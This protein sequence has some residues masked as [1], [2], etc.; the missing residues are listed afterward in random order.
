MRASYSFIIIIAI[1]I[2]LQACKTDISVNTNKK[3]DVVAKNLQIAWGLAYL[4]NGDF[5]F[6]ERM[7]GKIYLIKKG[8]TEP[9]VL[10]Q[11]SI[12]PDGEGGLLG[13]A[14]D[15]E[16]NQNHYIF[17]YE[18]TSANRVVRLRYDN[19]TLAEDAV[20]VDGIPSATYHNGGGLKFGP[21]GYL[22]IGTGDARVPENAQDKNSV[23]GKILRVDRNGNAA[24]G[25]PFNNKVWTYGHRNVQGFAW[26]NNG[27]ML[28][29]EHGPSGENGWYAH[30]EINLIQP[31]KNYGWPLVIGAPHVDTLMDPVYQSGD[32]TWAPSGITFITG[33]QWDAWQNNFIYCALKGQRLIRF[34]V[35]ASGKGTMITDTLQSVYGR[36]R[37]IIEAPDGSLIFSSSNTSETQTMPDDDK[38]YRMY[39][40]AQ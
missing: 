39:N 36:L 26:D 31:G 22:Y 5:M 18:T 20:I 37:N 25:N 10:L 6:T 40:S 27:L 33:G 16:F 11:R 3:I 2:G 13:L 12:N 32:D 8:E 19:N 4:P 30:D 1:L 24:P 35:N 9:T 17:I 28:A 14:I 29:T 34:T 38:I 21:D 15:P 7:T 23:S